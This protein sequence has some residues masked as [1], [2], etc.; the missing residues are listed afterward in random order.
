MRLAADRPGGEPLV[1]RTAALPEVPDLI[2]HLPA[3]GGVAWI[4]GGDGF[5]GW[6]EAVRVPVGTGPDR[7][8]RAARTVAGLLGDSEVH[9]EVGGWGTG[10]LAFGSFAFDDD[11]AASD[12]VVPAVVIGSAG[13]RDWVT[14]TGLGERAGPSARSPWRGP[15]AGGPRPTRTGSL[16]PGCLRRARTAGSTTWRS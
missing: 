2:A 13:G 12:L 16:G 5:V 6:G 7:F 1:S 15:P 3:A 10:P 8:A 14:R 4:R 11:A 9:N